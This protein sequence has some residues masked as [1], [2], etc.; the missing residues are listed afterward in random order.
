MEIL[1]SV[2]I[3][4]ANYWNINS[5]GRKEHDFSPSRKIPQGDHIA[6]YLVTR[7]RGKLQPWQ[8][9]ISESAN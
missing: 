3:S 8:I 6:L 5:C 7:Y 1:D 9:V 4:E 2:T